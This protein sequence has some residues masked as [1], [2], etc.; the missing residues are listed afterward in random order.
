MAQILMLGKSSRQGCGKHGRSIRKASF[1]SL[2]APVSPVAITLM[3]LTRF[4]CL[5]SEKF[6]VVLTCF[7]G[8]ALRRREQP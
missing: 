6:K 8:P 1:P 4:V 3:T 5:T 7:T 2:L